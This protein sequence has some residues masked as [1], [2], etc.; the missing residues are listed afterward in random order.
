MQPNV[1]VKPL[2]NLFTLFLI[3]ISGVMLASCGGNPSQDDRQQDSPTLQSPD[4]Q[5]ENEES[6]AQDKQ[7][8]NEGSEGKNKGKDA[9]KQ[10]EDKEEDDDD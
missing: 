6:E 9:E 1:M 4:N 7:G 5:S 3:M 8:E 2:S 10:R